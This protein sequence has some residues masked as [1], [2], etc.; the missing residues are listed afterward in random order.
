METLIWFLIFKGNL[1][2]ALI[3][4]YPESNMDTELVNKLMYTYDVFIAVRQKSRQSTL[5]IIIKGIEKFITNIYEARYQLLKMTGPRVLAEIPPTYFN[6]SDHANQRTNS[7]VSLL[8]STATNNLQTLSPVPPMNWMSSWPGH[9]HSQKNYTM[10][11]TSMPNISNIRDFR[12][13]SNANN[14]NNVDKNLNVSPRNISISSG[15]QSINCSMSSVES[16]LFN[17]ATEKDY[18]HGP[19]VDTSSTLNDSL[20]FDF[21]RR[22]VSGYNAMKCTPSEREIR[23]PTRHWQG[24]G[25]SR[26]SPHPME[27]NQEENDWPRNT[28]TPFAMTTSILDSVP[29]PQR[30]RLSQY[31]DVASI[32]VN[33]GLEH[34]IRKFIL[35]LYYYSIL[36]CVARYIFHKKVGS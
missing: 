19:P 21:D 27:Q 30:D 17:V 29:R 25:L 31:N 10:T 22:I 33:I 20:I 35:F 15:Y 6:L 36:I 3:F 4:D 16:N 2:I 1:P 26:T 24:L 5:C 28:S 14:N 32:L 23:T 34:H 18:K 12:G 7:I 8:A 11:S 13:C 9:R